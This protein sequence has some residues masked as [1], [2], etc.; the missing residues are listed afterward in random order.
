MRGTKRG[1]DDNAIEHG[2]MVVQWLWWIDPP[3]IAISVA[4]AVVL[5]FR[6]V[7]C[8]FLG[9]QLRENSAIVA[10]QF[11]SSLKA[12]SGHRPTLA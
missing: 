10:P 2:G 1:L 5:E 6:V 3:A 11:S 4:G 9:V 7:M 8:T 12:L